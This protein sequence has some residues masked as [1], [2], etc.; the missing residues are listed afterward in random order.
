M[1]L[2]S[3]ELFPWEQFGHGGS[4]PLRSMLALRGNPPGGVY[5]PGDT[6]VPGNSFV[7]REIILLEICILLKIEHGGALR[8]HMVDMI[9]RPKLKF[10]R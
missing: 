4:N 6:N 8:V 9:L 5:D 1:Y 7:P 2:W 3:R 10:I